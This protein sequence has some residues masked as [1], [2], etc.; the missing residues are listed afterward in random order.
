MVTMRRSRAL[1]G[2]VLAAVLALA[3]CGGGGSGPPVSDAAVDLP[4][5]CRP[6]DRFQTVEKGVLTLPVVNLLPIFLFRPGEPM[7]GIEGRII[8]RFVQKMCLPVRV[9]PQGEN[10]YVQA[11]QAGRGDIAVG[12]AYMTPERDAVVDFSA[13][14]W[15]DYLTFLSA[16]G[17]RSVEEVRDKTVGTVQGYPFVQDLTKVVADVRLYPSAE[18]SLNDLYVGRID[19][20]ADGLT[21]AAGNLAKAGKTGQIK[22]EIIQPHPGIVATQQPARFAFPYTQGNDELGAALTETIEELRRSG[23]LAA[24]L[25]E[26]GIDPAAADVG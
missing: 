9:L 16:E 5:G 17:Y 11:V 20:V 18:A 25:Q 13:P 4:A 2:A 12:G 7:Q 8:T 24:I 15:R 26:Y 19:V 23:E 3:A 14:T 22:A 21:L 1:V 6:T 10:S